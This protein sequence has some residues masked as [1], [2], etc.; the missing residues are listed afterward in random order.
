MCRDTIV[1]AFK[2][3][4]TS[5]DQRNQEMARKSKQARAAAKG[6]PSLGGKPVMSLSN[7]PPGSAGSGQSMTSPASS[8][9]MLSPQTQSPMSPSAGMENIFKGQTNQDTLADGYP[10]AS[11]MMPGGLAQQGRQQMP[12]S[13]AGYNRQL[14][15]KAG[16]LMSQGEMLSPTHSELQQQMAIGHAPQG[17]M[18]MTDINEPPYAQHFGQQQPPPPP[19]PPPPQPELQQ[20]YYHQQPMQQNQQYPYQQ[21]QQYGQNAYDQVC[22]LHLFRI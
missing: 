3:Q 2:Q 21:Q 15:I 13:S 12:P 9:P 7:K 20:P 10:P 22:V 18:L 17:G 14:G 5:Q 6:I 19:P 1:Q 8:K 11:G 4:E 16:P